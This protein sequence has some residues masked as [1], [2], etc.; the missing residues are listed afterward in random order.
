MDTSNSTIS[1]I[2]FIAGRATLSFGMTRE[3]YADLFDVVNE[4]IA[5]FLPYLGMTPADQIRGQGLR[6][7]DDRMSVWE[8]IR[9]TRLVRIFV[10]QG[11]EERVYKVRH[12]LQEVYLTEQGHW[13]IVPFFGRFDDWVLIEN[14]S[15]FLAYYD[16]HV[17]HPSWWLIAGPQFVAQRAIEKAEARLASLAGLERKLAEMDRRHQLIDG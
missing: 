14:R 4:L 5:P 16:D 9:H 6:R 8:Q 1:T 3:D 17:L 7:F 13:L 2:D 10:S 15:D 12:S 11:A